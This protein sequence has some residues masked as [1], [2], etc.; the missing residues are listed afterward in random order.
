MAVSMERF[1]RQDCTFQKAS[2]QRM[3]LCVQPKKKVDIARLRMI[4]KAE[5]AFSS[6]LVSLHTPGTRISFWQSTRQS[7]ND[8]ERKYAARTI[9]GRSQRARFGPTCQQRCDAPGGHDGGNVIA[10][11]EA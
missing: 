11:A 9:C 4:I 3:F 5:S 10:S 8:L 7:P 2:L 1:G 6:Q